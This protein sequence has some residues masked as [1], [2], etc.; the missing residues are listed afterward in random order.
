MSDSLTCTFSTSTNFLT[1]T[2]PVTSARKGTLSFNIN[3]A[4]KNPY[5]TAPIQGYYIQTIDSLG[6]I[7][8]KSNP[9]TVFV[10]S[11]AS[12]AS[13]SITRADSNK[14]VNALSKLRL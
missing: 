2:G 8:E 9:F 12:M 14:G 5:S 4:F 11:W 7:I 10:N 13:G 3:A 1:V 6:K